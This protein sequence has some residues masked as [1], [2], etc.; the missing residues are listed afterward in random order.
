[1]E[2]QLYRHRGSSHKTYK[3]TQ[4]IQP[5]ENKL[6]RQPYNISKTV[7]DSYNNN[8]YNRGLDNN[9]IIHQYDRGTIQ[10]VR[11]SSYWLCRAAEQE[12][13]IERERNAL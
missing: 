6:R 11:L 7:V 9:N 3:Y 8:K 10:S 4:C 2:R 13:L 12:M 1:M 5:G